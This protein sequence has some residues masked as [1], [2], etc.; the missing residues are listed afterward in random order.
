MAGIVRFCA[1][2]KVFQFGDA[3]AI[4]CADT[5]EHAREAAK[6][7]KV[8]LEVLPAYMSA[9]AAMAPDAIEIHAGI[10]NIYFEQGVVKGDDTKSIMEDPDVVTVEVDTYCS[11]QPHLVLEPDCGCAYYDEEGRLTIHSKSIALHLHHAMICPGLGIEPDKLRLVAN[12]TGATFGYKFSPT[13]E[14]LLGVA[15]MATGR[16]VSLNFSMF[17][18]ITYTGKRSPG[19]VKCKLAADKTGKLL[20]METDWF[21]DHG[22]YSEFGDLLTLRQAQFTGAGYDIPNI[23]G[24]GRTVCTNHAWGSAFRAYG[25]PTSLLGFGNR[26]G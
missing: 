24:K 16:P 19:F 23:R 15:C 4:V 10:P 7:V 22:P 21:I 14:A 12:P 13:N 11:R 5:E 3:I 25:S 26:Y 2:R 9:P 1:T 8:D 20:G 6:K 18:M 17:Q